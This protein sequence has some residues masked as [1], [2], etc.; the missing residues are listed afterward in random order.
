MEMGIVGVEPISHVNNIFI[1]HG[2]AVFYVCNGETLWLQKQA[3]PSHAITRTQ[4]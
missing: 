1:I 3:C 2:G 4:N